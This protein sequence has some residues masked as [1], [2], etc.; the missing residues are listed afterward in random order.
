MYF[1][2]FP[3]Q[4]FCRVPLFF[5]LK[6]LH[7]PTFPPPQ[8]KKVRG[9]EEENR[10]T[11]AKTQQAHVTENESTENVLKS[12]HNIRTWREVVKFSKD[13]PKKDR[14]VETKPGTQK[15]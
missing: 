9:H 1:P 7:S 15:G 10:W 2:N 8:A 13:K 14:S 4:E 11:T 12:D 5:L 6:S 3:T